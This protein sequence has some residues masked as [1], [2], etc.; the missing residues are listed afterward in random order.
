MS[1][2]YSLNGD[3]NYCYLYMQQLK[4]CHRQKMYPHTKC[5]H[6]REDYLECHNKKKYVLPLFKFSMTMH[7]KYLELFAKT[8]T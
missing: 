3:L 8:K 1:S 2:A 7:V 6:E 4:E 5:A